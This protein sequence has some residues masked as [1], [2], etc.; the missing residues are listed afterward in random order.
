MAPVKGT[1][2]R[3]YPTEADILEDFIRRKPTRPIPMKNY[4]PTT[5]RKDASWVSSTG[6]HTILAKDFAGGSLK[7]E[8]CLQETAKE[9]QQLKKHLRNQFY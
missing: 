2:T 8:P 7:N 9:L 3:V 4:A 6:R 5:R 1:L